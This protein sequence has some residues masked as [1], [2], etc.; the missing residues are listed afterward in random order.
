MGT[1][2]M[3]EPS[4]VADALESAWAEVVNLES[5]AFYRE[6][7]DLVD[8]LA[9]LPAHRVL[10]LALGALGGAATRADAGRPRSEGLPS[11]PEEGAEALAEAGAA[12]AAAL[13]QWL[14]RLFDEPS[15]REAQMEALAAFQAGAY[16][17]SEVGDVGLDGASALLDD[18]LVTGRLA[19]ALLGSPSDEDTVPSDLREPP[20]VEALLEYAE[21]LP[22]KAWVR[23]PADGGEIFQVECAG[24]ILRREGAYALLE[25]ESVSDLRTGSVSEFP[26]KSG[27]AALAVVREEFVHGLSEVPRRSVVR[28][29]LESGFAG[30]VL[31]SNAASEPL[32]SQPSGEN[33]GG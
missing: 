5:D 15:M 2:S 32:D 31:V 24:R 1:S 8:A 9:E 25:L 10:G 22:G 28:L 17:A 21:Q 27:E 13:E 20:E 12:C 16:S 14:Y 23:M 3:S 33:R 11:E 29:S 19:A 6:Y 30:H 26:G 18:M 7:G 4:V